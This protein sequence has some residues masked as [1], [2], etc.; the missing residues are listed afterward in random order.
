MKI[1]VLTRIKPALLAGFLRPR[2]WDRP[3]GHMRGR[4]AVRWLLW[5]VFRIYDGEVLYRRDVPTVTFTQ[6][7]L[8]GAVAPAAWASPS[9]DSVVLPVQGAAPKAGNTCRIVC[10]PAPLGAGMAQGG[11]SD[12]L[13]VMQPGL[14]QTRNAVVPKFSGNLDFLPKKSGRTNFRP[15]LFWIFQISTGKFLG[16]SNFAPTFFRFFNFQPE[17][18]FGFRNFAAEKSPGFP[19]LVPGPCRRI[20]DGDAS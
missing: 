5:V 19:V 1:T 17:I 12:P 10:A 20:H 14:A 13:K 15:E 6:K 8:L 3:V 16:F 7:T 11:L 2:F 9:C 4:S 18:F